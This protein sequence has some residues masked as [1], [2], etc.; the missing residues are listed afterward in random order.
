MWIATGMW[1]ARSMSLR[2]TTALHLVTIA[3]GVGIEATTSITTIGI[4][5]LDNPL[6]GRSPRTWR[7]R[8]NA[9]VGQDREVWV[10]CLAGG[11]LLCSIGQAFPNLSS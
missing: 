7:R 2:V 5:R 8:I 1:I 3:A 11:I 6:I 9:G 4:E 10:E